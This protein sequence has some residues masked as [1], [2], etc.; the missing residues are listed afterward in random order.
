[1][2]CSFRATLLSR[3]HHVQQVTPN[4][5]EFTVCIMGNSSSTIWNW[6]KM[7]KHPT[8]VWDYII[9]FFFFFVTRIIQFS[10]QR[11]ITVKEVSGVWFRIIKIKRNCT[12]LSI[13]NTRISLKATVTSL[14]LKEM[15]WLS[16]RKF[17]ISHLKG[18]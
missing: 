9:R 8:T 18:H 13:F 3:G 10:N 7:W 5:Q 2:M 11:V 1:M 14:S 6:G 17:H 15:Y 12:P 16:S 4:L